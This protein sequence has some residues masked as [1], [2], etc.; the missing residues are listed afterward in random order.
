M[1]QC[2]SST[3]DTPAL[4]P[5]FGV[6]FRFSS[7]GPIGCGMLAALSPSGEQAALVGMRAVGLFKV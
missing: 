2:P 3:R 5:E 6:R 4:A 1:T 7:L